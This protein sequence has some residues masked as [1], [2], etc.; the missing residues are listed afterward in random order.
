[1]LNIGKTA[2]IVSML[3]TF[4]AC[5]DPAPPPSDTTAAPTSTDA[6]P[7]AAADTPLPAT[8]E[9]A[10]G[11][12]GELTLGFT[13]TS[14]IETPGEFAQLIVFNRNTQITCPIVA[15][16]VQ[17]ISMISGATPE[18][19][20]AQAQLGA[21]AT[22]QIEAIPPDII[23]TANALEKQKGTCRKAG[24]SRKEC[25][26]Q[27]MAATQSN[28][29][30]LKQMG[31]MAQTDP[32]GRELAEAAMENAASRLQPWFNE[33]CRGSMTVAD[34]YWANDPTLAGPEPTI[35]TTGTETIDTNDTLVTVETDLGKGSTRY[36]IVMPQESGFQQE[37]GYGNEARLVSA[38]AMPEPVVIAGPFPGPIQNGAH[39]YPV[40]GG[41]VAIHWTFKPLR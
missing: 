30:L 21:V 27:M 15:S 11:S 24:G 33:G 39:S 1:M 25:D 13:W 40:E 22:A 16:S 18:Q 23:A 2:A 38:G 34:S 5:S 28:P 14:R 31:Q 29:E 9:V 10:D 19:E 37:A 17:S 4:A 26:M 36:M 20:A 6:T 8:I 35:H 3:L 7:I 41:T 32:E 12:K